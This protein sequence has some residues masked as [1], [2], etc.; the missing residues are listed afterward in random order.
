MLTRELAIADYENG[1]V[2]PDRLTRRSHV[3]YV[4]LAE[5]LLDVYRNGIGRT[6]RELHRDAHAAFAGECDCPLRRIE[7]FC[8]LLDD[9]STYGHG[10]RG[11]PAAL[12]RKVFRLAA[13]LHPLVRCADRLFAHEETAAK[14]TIA[15][16]LGLSWTE[17]DQ[18]LFA[19]VME[20]HR[21]T[22]FAGYPSGEALLARYNVA[23][24]QAALFRAQEM[25]VWATA[26]F[27]TIL[28]YA[29]LARLMHTIRRLG[30]S[31]Y[32]IRF[33]G[34][35]SV[36]RGTRRYGVALARFLPA[37]VACRGWRLH[38]VLQTRRR[39][40][41]VRL[42]LSAEEGLHSH[43]PPPEVFDSSVEESFAQRWGEKREGWAL[44]REGEVLHQGQKT[45]VAD[46]VLRHDDGRRVL[47]EIVGFWTPEYLQ[48]KFQRLH[49]FQDQHI[50]VAV[51]AAA[52]RQVI[53]LPPGAI[54][55]KKVLRPQDVLER[56]MEL[57]G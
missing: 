10:R 17:I 51:A 15:G 30:E 50:L 39:G 22:A 23:Q 40:W 13:A 26:D 16:Q 44:E 45:F 21:L 7:A 34:P 57:G 14:A 46:F 54:R 2:L 3:H 37:L 33:D 55:F 32:E 6:R 41:L 47:L 31:R 42:D 48:A 49:A 4:A 19:D 11:A 25:V 36:L 20:C 8:K 52:G 24:I 35:A 38:A 1:R 9:Q 43:L 29:K 12:R 56:L 53:E 28:R 5:R 27:K 18:Q